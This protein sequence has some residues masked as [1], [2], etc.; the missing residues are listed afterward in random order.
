MRE[1]HPFLFRILSVSP[2]HALIVSILVSALFVV[3][4]ISGIIGTN[5]TYSAVGFIFGWES[6]AVYFTVHIAREA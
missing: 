3:A 5:L 4:T 1:R 2:L 6:A